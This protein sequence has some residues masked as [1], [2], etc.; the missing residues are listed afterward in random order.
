[1][2]AMRVATTAFEQGAESPLWAVLGYGAGW[3]DT[4]DRSGYTDSMGFAFAN[5]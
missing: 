5:K 1:M 4:I 2:S 3:H